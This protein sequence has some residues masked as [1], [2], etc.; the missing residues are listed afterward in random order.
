MKKLTIY[1]GA[2]AVMLGGCLKEGEIK[3]PYTG[4]APV[5]IN[6]GWTLSDPASE[7]IDPVA[8]DQVYRDI[9]ADDELWMTKSL[10]VFRNGRLVAESYLKSDEDRTKPDAI[11]SCTKQINGIITGIAI[12]RG[13]IDSVTDPVGDYLP[14]YVESHPDKAPITLE[15]LLMMKSGTSFNNDNQTDVFREHKTDNS[16]EYVFS[17]P[18]AHEPGTFYSYNDGDPQIV[19]GIVQ[20]ATGKTL[21]VFGKEVFLDKIGFTNYEWYDYSDG[22][23]LGAF[24]I[25]TTGREMA[26]V[27]QCVLDGGVWNGEQVIPE[28]WIEEMLTIRTDIGDGT[29]F[30]YYWW[31]YPSRGY[32]YM[33]GH[34]GQMA[35]ILPEKELLVIITSLVQVD[36]DV[37]VPLEK[38]IGIADQ[39]AAIAD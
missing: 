36:D 6:D 11:W 34:G 14:D 12:D 3:Q 37:N 30:G 16:L 5:D 33:H 24:G 23:T 8:L 2:L 25:L 31:I 20:A 19:S 17:L 7:G 26:K 21:A 29:A 32:Y 1:I 15:M 9:Y 38:L 4:Y 13:Y 22:V 28:W 27:A 39:V 10:L 18:L 35:F